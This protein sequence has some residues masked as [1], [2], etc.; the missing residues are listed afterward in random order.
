MRAFTSKTRDRVA[1]AILAGGLV[2]TGAGAAGAQPILTR[3]GAAGAPTGTWAQDGYGPGHAG[4]NPGETAITTKNVATLAYRWSIVSPVVRDACGQQDPPVVG[5]GRLFLTDQ[6]G[7]GAYDAATGHRLWTVAWSDPA[8]EIAPALALDG[9]TLLVATDDCQSVS[10]PDGELTAYNVATG[11][12][13]WAVHRDAPFYSMVVDAGIVVAAGGDAGADETSAYRVSNGHAQWNRFNTAL[14]V[15][16]EFGG[17][18]LLQRTDGTGAVAV[19]LTTG[20]KIWQTSKNWF[21]EAAGGS[22]F[23]VDANDTDLV[24]V[25]AATGAVAW[26]AHGDANSNAGATIAVDTTRVYATV[27]D[28][29]IALNAATGTPAWDTS[30]GDRTGRPIVAGGVVYATD[31]A[32]PGDV[33]D[34]KTGADLDPD[35]PYRMEIGHAVVAG[36]WLYVTDGRVTD[37]FSN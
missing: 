10:D 25:N 26:T 6:R 14:P 29:I 1:A 8:D 24:S 21:A 5:G 22:H 31:P 36:G 34:A 23:Y 19:R 7:F 18:L 15:G 32:E 33:L 20:A 16:V 4:Y 2:L 17:R 3:A 12:V 37:A 11:A 28:D 35:A 13:R 30:I 27:G 9:S